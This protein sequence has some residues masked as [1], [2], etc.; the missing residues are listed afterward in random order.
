MWYLN[1]YVQLEYAALDAAVL[2]H[3]FWHVRNQSQ[4]QSS[5]VS[6]EHNNNTQ[7]EW[8][9]H[10]VSTKTLLQIYSLYTS[11]RLTVL[12]CFFFT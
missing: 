10:I 5:D 2:I 8:K 6:N 1:A 4:I 7:M 9:S 11:I 3:I 12:Y